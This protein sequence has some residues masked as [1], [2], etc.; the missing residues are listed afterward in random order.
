MY[1]AFWDYNNMPMELYPKIIKQIGTFIIPVFLIT[2]W[3]GMAVLGKLS[4][5]ELI[6]GACFPVAAF[7]LSRLMWKRGI[8]KYVSA[9]G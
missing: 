7:L 1:C 9:N 6:W 2:N 3:Q 8:K 4:V 5:V